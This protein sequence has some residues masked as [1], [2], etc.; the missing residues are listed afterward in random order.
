VNAHHL[1]AR[2]VLFYRNYTDHEKPYPQL[3]FVSCATLILKRK[4]SA[5][6]GVKSQLTIHGISTPF[7]VVVHLQAHTKNMRMYASFPIA[8]SVS[9][10]GIVATEKDVHGRKKKT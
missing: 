10:H 1:D 9:T 5:S 2:D 8:G 6:S 3:Y 7:V 4:S